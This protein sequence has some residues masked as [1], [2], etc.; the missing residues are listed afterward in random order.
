MG[1]LQLQTLIIILESE[2]ELH[3]VLHFKMD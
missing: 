2:S 3:I 1:T